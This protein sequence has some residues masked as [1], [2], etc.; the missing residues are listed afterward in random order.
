[1]SKILKPLPEIGT[2]YNYLCNE[3]SRARMATNQINK[4]VW[5]V[6]TI[7]QAKRI[8]FEDINRRWL[9][10]DMSEGLEIPKRT[11]HKWRIAIEEIFGLLIEN[12][13]CGEYRY[14]ILNDDEIS[15]G[16]L[17]TWLVNTI[18]VSNL[19]T[20]NQS[21]KD[22]IVLEDIPSGRLFLPSILEALKE[23]T[24]LRITYQSFWKNEA[25]TFDVEPYC[26]KLFRQRWYL[27]AHSTYYN[28]VMIYAVDRMSEVHKTSTPFDYPKDFTPEEFFYGCFGVIAGDGTKIEH[29]ELQVSAGKANYLRSLPLHQSQIESYRSDEYSIFE[30][31]IRPTFDFQLEILA[32]TPDIEVLSPIWLREEIAGKIA[33]MNKKYRSAK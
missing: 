31:Q 26:V 24:L 7:H 17:R 15:R 13:N 25:F 21:I 4:Y 10:N 32:H 14:Y 18:A 30:Y 28:K 19:I 11:F 16:G 2:L 22:R 33:Y 1:M 9:T 5:L 3:K 8:S 27:V 12:E 29:V 23:E 6:D 20:N